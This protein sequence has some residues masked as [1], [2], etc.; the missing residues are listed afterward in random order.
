MAAVPSR[1]LNK[2]GRKD[3]FELFGYDFI[4]DLSGKTWLI[5]INTNPSLEESNNYL[6]KL[7]PKLIDDAFKLTLDQVFPLPQHKIEPK[8]DISLTDL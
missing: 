8:R 6:K 7:F 5:E 3:C 1:L 4:I 2:N